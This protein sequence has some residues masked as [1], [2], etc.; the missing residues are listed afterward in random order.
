MENETELVERAQQGDLKAFRQLVTEYRAMVYRLAYDLTRSREDA[1]DLSQE[2]FIKAYRSLK[3][4]RRDAKFSSWLYRITVNASLSLKSKKSYLEMKMQ[5][6]IEQVK[7]TEAVT[8][9]SSGANP[10]KE[11]EFGFIRNHVEQALAKLSARE[12]AIFI[13]RNYCGMSFEEI[14]EILK[15]RPGTARN[16]NFK[17]LRKL[18][19]ELAFYKKEI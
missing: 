5:K 1:E 4:F 18:R 10:E 14:V 19:K 9:D 8:D 15:I 7:E 6:D 12:K 3:S 2:V 13:M 17:A 16:F 11:T